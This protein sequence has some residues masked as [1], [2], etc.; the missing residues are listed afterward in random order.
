MSYFT[1]DVLKKTKAII[2]ELQ[3]TTGTTGS[4]VVSGGTTTR[5]GY[6]VVLLIGQSNIRIRTTPPLSW[7][8]L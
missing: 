2:A 5:A 1:K 8:T 3:A 4:T 7:W 6:D